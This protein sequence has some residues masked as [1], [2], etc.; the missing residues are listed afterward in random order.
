LA[1][2]LLEHPA[3]EVNAINQEGNTPLNYFAK[4]WKD[5]S[6]MTKPLLQLFIDHGIERERER[7][8][9]RAIGPTRITY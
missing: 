7:E 4:N 2:A 3:I 6:P 8:R 9:E 5:D 1:K